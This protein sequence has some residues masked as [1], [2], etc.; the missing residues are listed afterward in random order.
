MPENGSRHLGKLE[1]GIAAAI[2]A[3]GLDSGLAPVNVKTTIEGWSMNA[4]QMIQRIKTACRF[5]KHSMQ[6]G[7]AAA[8]GIGDADAVAEEKAQ[9]WLLNLQAMTDDPFL[10]TYLQNHAKRLAASMSLTPLPAS[11]KAALLELASWGP[12]LPYFKQEMGY[13][14]VAGIDYGDET[15]KHIDAITIGEL[16]FPYARLDIESVPF[17]FPDGMF[18][19]VL[20]WEI[21][22]HMAYDPMFMLSEIN[23]VLKSDGRLFITTPNIASARSLEALLCGGQPQLY[24]AY[25]KK[26][27]LDR[28]HIEYSPPEM[29]KLMDAAGFIPEL[30]ETYDCYSDHHAQTIAL[31]D[32]HG[33]PTTYRGDTMFVVGRKAGPV[34]TRYPA[35]IYD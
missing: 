30:F 20:A 7:Y 11:E 28:H 15:Q 5:L 1:G 25:N 17:P 9:H 23:R 27:V 4:K 29:M 33:Y 8:M 35:P 6:N 32:T 26:R 31:L 14:Q 16:S 2:A 18:D 24:A 19:V 34:K 13:H 22:E 12:L 3:P 10:R 21:I